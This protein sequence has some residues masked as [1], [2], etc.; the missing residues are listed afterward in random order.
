M[1]VLVAGDPRS[2]HAACFAALLRELGHEVH[3][4]AIE[5]QYEQ[6]EHLRDVVLH[7]PLAYRGALN[8]NRIEGRAAWLAGL[9]RAEPAHHTLSHLLYC[10]AAPGR[11]CGVGRLARTIAALSPAL[12]FS[13]KMQNEGYAVAGARAL[14]GSA[15]RAPWVHFTWGTDIEFFGKHSGHAARHLPMI[16]DL[17]ARCD[18]HIADTQRDIDQAVALGFT[19]Q[20]LGVMP[21]NGGFDLPRLRHLRTSGRGRRDTVLIKGRH[22]GYV[23]K[24]L[25]VLMVIR[26]R[27]EIFRGLRVRFFMA[28]PE[29][30]AQARS[31]QR[32]T[33]LDCEVLP[34]LAHEDLMC[35]YARALIAISASD[36]DGTPAF[37]LEAM[38]MGA[39]PIHSDMASLRE[40]VE[41][42]YN[43]LLFPVDDVKALA[44]CIERGLAD[45]TLR[46]QAA[47]HNWRLIEERADRDKLRERL[48]KWIEAATRA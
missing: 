6:E 15:F 26:S 21:A 16:R 1:R 38:A 20:S 39:L 14:M 19:G 48:R 46:A 41:H 3:L 2:I 17:L 29:V 44:A 35:W 43:G 18:F 24:A 13:L 36:V 7:V 32:D 8:G 25:N 37:L 30:A 10:L 4:F 34:R 33:G 27:P 42:G 9:C 45:A 28:T 31:L 12:V 5:L 23:G 40:W 22:G 11:V 47:Q